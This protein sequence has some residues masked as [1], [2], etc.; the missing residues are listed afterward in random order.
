MK[1]SR[2]TLTLSALALAAAS[3]TANA[4]ILFQNL[5]TAAPPATIGSHTMTP[6]DAAPQNAIPD[7]TSGI[8]IIPGNPG[9]GEL[10]IN[11]SASKFTAPYSWVSEWAGGNVGAVYRINPYN[12]VNEVT[13][14]LPAGTTAFYFY[15]SPHAYGTYDMSAVTDTGVS[16]GMIPVA[17]GDGGSSGFAFYSTAG[18]SISSITVS[19]HSNVG[20][21]VGFF[22][23]DQGPTTTCASEGYTGTKLTWCRNICEIEHT[24]AVHASWIH[25]WVNRYRDLPYCAVEGGGEEEPPQEG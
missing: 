3:F 13:L 11:H 6:F 16:S 19:V 12:E 4:D 5:G 15:T 14:T 21:G 10:S 2:L 18:E 8:T 22:G 23:I 24:P 9:S 20:L 1:A 25:R 7:G 17:T